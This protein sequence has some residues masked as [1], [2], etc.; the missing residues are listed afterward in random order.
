MYVINISVNFLKTKWNHDSQF[1]IQKS[2]RADSQAQWI[3]END[4]YLKVLR[5]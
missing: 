1:A 3:S 4:F 5:P 2:K